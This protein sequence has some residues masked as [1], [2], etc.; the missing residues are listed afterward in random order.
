MDFFKKIV[1]LKKPIQEH[2]FSSLLN[3]LSTK[4]FITLGNLLSKNFM[5]PKR[6]FY[7]TPR[8]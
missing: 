3:D 2:F 1:N 4:D 5:K 7:A 8:M 6:K